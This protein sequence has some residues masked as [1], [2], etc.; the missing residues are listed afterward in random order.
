MAKKDEAT[1]PQATVEIEQEVV[2]TPVE[3]T[4]PPPPQRSAPTQAQHD[5]LARNPHYIRSSH[6]YSRF[7]NRG[8]LH[9]DGTFV[10]ETVH[11]VMDGNG[12]F[13]VGIPLSR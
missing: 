4:P 5:W 6:A 1:E 11:P 8:T 13:G 9:P 10:P 12:C 3:M 2:A 7:I